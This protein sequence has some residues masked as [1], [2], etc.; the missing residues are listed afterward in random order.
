MLKLD[1][2][3]KYYNKDKAN[4]TKAVDGISI[5]FPET[6]LVVLLGKSGCG[7]STLLNLIAG[8]DG[9]TSGRICFDDK[10]FSGYNA[11]DWDG[12][13]GERI[14]FIFQNYNLI[15]DMTVY[16]NIELALKVANI[17][18][19]VED[20]INY[21]LSLVNMEKYTKRIP[22]SLSG[23]QQQRV[24]IARAIAKGPS[25]LIADEPTGN[26]DDTNTVA[27]MDI[28]KG[29]SKNCLVIMVTH[30]EK[31]ADFYADRIIR[32]SDGKIISDEDN[33]DS[34]AVLAH[35]AKDVIYLQDLPHEQA[36][37]KGYL[38]D[39][40]GNTTSDVRIKL[41]SIDN[42]LYL[43][44]DS[45]QII[46]L[47]DDN[48]SIKL[49]DKKFEVKERHEST[50]EVD[51]DKLSC[52]QRKKQRI[53]GFKDA[54]KRIFNEYNANK[55]KKKG[56]RFKTLYTAAVFFVLLMVMMGGNFVYDSSTMD[57]NSDNTIVVN[58]SYSKICDLVDKGTIE[59]HVLTKSI[60]D[61]AVVDSELYE[62]SNLVI[63]YSSNACIIPYSYLGKNVEDGK[64]YV[65][66]L[67]YDRLEKTGTLDNYGIFKSGQLVGCRLCLGYYS[68][69]EGYLDTIAYD[70]D[71]DYSEGDTYETAEK[72]SYII[73]GIVDLGSPLIYMSDNDYQN[74]Q[75]SI[76]DYYKAYEGNNT[77]LYTDEPSKCIKT[78]KELGIESNRVN[79][80]YRN[81]FY[82]SAF[83]MNVTSIILLVVIILVQIYAV[84]KLT[85]ARFIL[86]SRKLSIMRSLGV[87][88]MSVEGK[89]MLENISTF[90]LST[91]KGWFVTSLVMY[92]IDN[93][94]FMKNLENLFGSQIIFCPIWFLLL[95]LLV[96][97]AITIIVTFFI[98]LSFLIKKPS[99]LLTKYDL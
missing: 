44:V 63:A 64:V 3:Y 81:D 70:E 93:M 24:G 14:G 80:S 55:A 2:L 90:S 78:L 9:Q 53:F 28:L 49:L 6:G 34:D 5:D 39:F 71:F 59:G 12:L 77:F 47:V 46:N 40:Y 27:V 66:K 20:R 67:L 65:D 19:R 43:K 98:P 30:E 97:L 86:D 88:R 91:L 58:A 96:L 1:K 94:T 26:L 61:S 25:I 54:F 99:E 4:E 45:D 42:K 35:K 50:I 29:L 60:M 22:A 95:I 68:S 79:D 16:E 84:L 13:R 83:S 10:V 7:K 41:V 51:R 38:F 87:K 31:L 75:G 32:L 74:Y 18:D 85:K 73:A 82:K 37:V 15:P 36:D 56:N 17:S 57:I 33:S 48:S 76:N 72:Y 62:Y 21:A 8:L 69:K 23:G 11:A 89:L 92:I 52:N